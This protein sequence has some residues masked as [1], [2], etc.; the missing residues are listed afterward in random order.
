MP[1]ELDLHPRALYDE[2]GAG[3]QLSGRFESLL[4]PNK[5]RAC[6]AQGQPPLQSATLL[7][8]S[9]CEAGADV[10]HTPPH[11]PFDAL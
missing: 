10:P 11:T 3:D 5:L 7:Q 9:C 4:R 2:A 6:R 1:S 8:E